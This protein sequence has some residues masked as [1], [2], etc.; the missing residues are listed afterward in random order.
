MVHAPEQIAHQFVRD[1]IRNY[2]SSNRNRLRSDRENA[3]STRMLRRPIRN[4]SE[5]REAAQ[6]QVAILIL[7]RK[8]VEAEHTQEPELRALLVL[9]FHADVVHSGRGIGQ[10]DRLC[11]AAPK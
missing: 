1:V 9:G 8:W 3:S 5:I 10:N 11:A 7:V 2:N 6:Q 4:R